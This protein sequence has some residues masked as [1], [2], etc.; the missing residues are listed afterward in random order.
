MPD[1]TRALGDLALHHRKR[2][3]GLTI[4]IT[5]SAGK[6]TTKELTAAAL[7]GIGR[8]SCKSRGNLN[9]QFGVPMM[10]FC[11][12]DLHDTAVFEVGTSG[13]RGDRSTR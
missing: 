13:A 4:A 12:S 5:G 3:G 8:T 10:V 2:W 7:T 6:T 9:N 1:T 11:L